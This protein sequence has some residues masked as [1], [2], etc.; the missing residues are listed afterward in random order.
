MQ[1]SS[2]FRENLS[3]RVTQLESHS[4]VELVVVILDQSGSYADID[5]LWG[6]GAAMA[7]L[8][9]M[10]H[11]PLEFPPDLVVL[12]TVAIYTVGLA[13]SHKFHAIRR[14]LATRARRQTQVLDQARICFVSEGVADT[15]ERSGILLLISGLERRAVILPDIGVEARVPRSVFNQLEHEWSESSSLQDFETRVLQ[16]LAGLAEPLAKALPRRSDDSNELSDEIRL[17]V[18][19]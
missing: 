19:R 3:Q 11:T 17:K 15:R 2:S 13:V 7:G 12:L 18:A 4:S 16:G 5:H 10:I 1:F 6:F 14:L 8:T 9:V